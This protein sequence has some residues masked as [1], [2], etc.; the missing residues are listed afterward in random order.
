M[1]Q[2][3][4]PMRL[5]FESPALPNGIRVGDRVGAGRIPFGGSH[6]SCWGMPLVGTVLALDDVRA[7]AGT[8]SFPEKEPEQ[9]LVSLHVRD[10]LYA[11]TLSMVPVLWEPDG[12]RHECIVKWENPA[13]LRSVEADLAAFEKARAL[14][15]VHA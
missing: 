11:G 4:L 13:N 3:T 5:P 9:M 8:M 7:W 1:R 15:N 14:G 10:C 6:P 12:F 2:T